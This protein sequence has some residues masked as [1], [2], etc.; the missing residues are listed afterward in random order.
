MAL[1]NILQ[2]IAQPKASD[3]S[4]ALGRGLQQGSA[5]RANVDRSNLLQQTASEQGQRFKEVTD[6]N[7]MIEMSNDLNTAL[8]L[9][10]GQAQTDLLKQVLAKAPEG[11]APQI[12][13]N[14]MLSTPDPI[15]LQEKLKTTTDRAIQQGLLQP[16]P[17]AE[18]TAGQLERELK[19]KEQT[20]LSGSKTPAIK[21]FEYSQA[22]PKFGKS[23]GGNV[24]LDK[25][26]DEQK[27]ELASVYNISRKMPMTGRSDA[28]KEFNIDIIQ[29]AL[30][31]QGQSGQTATETYFASLDKEGQTK[32]INA[33]QKK[34]GSMRSFSKNIDKQAAKI[35]ETAQKI[36][37]M[38]TKI[39]NYPV[40]KIMRDYVGSADR[41]VLQ[42]L[43]GEL[44]EEIGKLASGATDSVAALSEGGREKWDHIFDVNLS[45]KDMLQLVEESK[46]VAKMRVDSMKES[47]VDSKKIRLGQKIDTPE[48]E[49][50]TIEVTSQSQFDKLP[51]GAI[52]IEDGKQYR[53]P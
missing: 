16:M 44:S 26:T 15:A 7:L 11:S 31:L 6:K 48:V 41:A 10:P 35:E 51:S 45:T 36:F 49:T 33:Q 27:D 20:A 40:N 19:A 17:K 42:L 47:L 12:V 8:S 38:D 22:N 30:K 23:Q 24:F 13:V 18:K 46:E 34:L 25:L 28:I 39:L 9:G 4:G 52:F 1:E 53:K 14:D 3:P 2:L 37:K 32:D 5:Y 21:E 43:V 29:R 50:E